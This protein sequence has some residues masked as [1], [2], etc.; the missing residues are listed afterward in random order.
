MPQPGVIGADLPS[1]SVES[2]RAR[3]AEIEASFPP[4]RRSSVSAV[5]FENALASAIS[6]TVPAPTSPSAGSGQR[7]LQA[8]RAE[9]GVREAPMGSNDSPRIAE[10]RSAVEWNPVGP[11]CAYFASWAAKQAGTPLGE[12]GQGFARVADTWDWARET[13]RAYGPQARPNPGDLVIMEGHMGI[14]E[15]VLPDGRVQTIEGNKSN[16]VSRTVRD[17]GEL[18]GFV[19]LG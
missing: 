8:A 4:L 2:V 16:Q 17:R 15:A 9:I 14:V 18:T 13:G 19:R 11:W 5:R 7:I 12:R 1:V 3:I 6:S 10:Y